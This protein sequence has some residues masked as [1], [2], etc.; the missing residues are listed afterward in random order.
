MASSAPL[1]E[2][3]QLALSGT[4]AQRRQLAAHGDSP[5]ELLMLL[6]SDASPQVRQAVADNSATPAH[7]DRLLCQDSLACIR[8][9]L[10][11]KLGAQAGELMREDLPR[12]LRLARDALL[13]LAQDVETT[14]RA[15]LADTLADLPDAPR[16]LVLA[17]AR[18]AVLEVCEP[19]IR[20]SAALREE[21]LLDFVDRPPHHHTRPAIARRLHVTGLVAEALLQTGEEATI[22]ALLRNTSVRLAPAA[23][24][25][26][27]EQAAALPWLQEA[28]A[29]HPHLPETALACLVGSLSREVLTRLAIQGSLPRGL[30]PSPRPALVWGAAPA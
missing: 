25:R 16:E 9:S 3:T 21:D 6:A 8:V 28:L 2:I 23:L 5:A 30:S 29:T 22:T 10:A 15:A 24:A 27:A 18:D 11:R 19:L 26:L 17:L 7:A 4:E 12:R 20:L 14:V 13:L 1:T